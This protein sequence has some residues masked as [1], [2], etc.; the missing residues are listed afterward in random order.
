MVAVDAVI[1]EG[2]SCNNASTSAEPPMP[3]LAPV[4][5]IG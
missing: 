1:I 5:A 3:I 2:L 4:K